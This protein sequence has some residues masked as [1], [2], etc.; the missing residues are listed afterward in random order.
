MA[1]DGMR[2]S[3]GTADMWSRY[4]CRSPSG[5]ANTQA[6]PTMARISASADW[7]SSRLTPGG[8]YSGID[9]SLSPAG[10]PA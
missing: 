1:A 6:A 9:I 2:S 4:G 5:S 10:A 7:K 3:G 8:R